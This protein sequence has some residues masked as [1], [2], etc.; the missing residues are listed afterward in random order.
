MSPVSSSGCSS[1]LSLHNRQFNILQYS[2]TLLLEVVS[3]GGS[4]SMLLLLPYGRGTSQ[5]GILAGSNGGRQLQQGRPQHSSL[6]SQN[7]CQQRGNC[8]LHVALGV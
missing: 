1:S 2:F 3:P 8:G 5:R 6:S 7:H 4:L